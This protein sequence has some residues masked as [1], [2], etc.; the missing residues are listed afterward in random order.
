MGGSIGGDI[1]SPRVE[2][3]GTVTVAVY[4]PEIGV[5]ANALLVIVELEALSR[6]CVPLAP[7]R[8]ALFI[9]TALVIALVVGLARSMLSPLA[10]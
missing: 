1:D 2:S 10:V 5:S 9:V 4:P 6:Y 3:A 8:A 7:D